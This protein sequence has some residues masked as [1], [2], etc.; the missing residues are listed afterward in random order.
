MRA[1][2]HFVG[3]EAYASGERQGDV[4]DPNNGGVQARVGLGSSADLE[5]AVGLCRDHAL[6]IGRD[7][8]HIGRSEAGVLR[9]PLIAAV[10]RHQH[11]ALAARCVQP[12]A[13]REIANKGIAEAVIECVP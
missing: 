1:I 2:S 5:R 7:R 11:A 10:G 9:G 8:G 13:N 6:G 3:G 12:I 4:F